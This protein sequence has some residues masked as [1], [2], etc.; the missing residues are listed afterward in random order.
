MLGPDIALAALINRLAN[1]YDT[2]MPPYMTFKEHTHIAV[3]V[4]GGKMKDVDRS[5]AVRVPDDYAV[6]QDLPAGGT[7]IG[8]A[9]PVVPFFD[10]FSTFSFSYFANPKKIDITFVPG[11]AW[12]LPLP[13]NDPSVD[14][15]VPYF[16]FILPRYAPDSTEDAPHWVIDP[17]PRTGNNFYISDVKVDAATQLPSHIELT[18]NGSDM[19]MGLDYSI[20]DSHW[21]VTHGTFSSTQRALG[22]SFKVTAE[23]TYS[24]FTFPTT[25]PD[26]RLAGSPRPRPSASAAPTASASP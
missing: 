2:S 26:P 21:V 15:V 23:T 6:M 20:V 17:T 14:V 25:P 1:V 11:D 8:S 24:E 4:F 18:Q 22:M 19:T 3:S 10:P 9:F 13:S 7:N 12:Q 5:V 16:S